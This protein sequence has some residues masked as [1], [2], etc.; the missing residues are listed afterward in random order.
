MNL[1]KVKVVLAILLIVAGIAGYY[2]LVS[3]G[4][5]VQVLV[6]IVSLLAAAGV[7]LTSASG[8]AF[9]LYA[10]ESVAEAKKVVWPTR[11]ET[12]QITGVVFVF[13][14]VLALFLW[15][16]DSLLSWAFHALLGRG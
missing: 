1:E 5:F 11:K 10:R 13:V 3:Q 4:M 7:M 14:F 8:K 15:G 2:Q 12:T 9:V 6:V 16:V